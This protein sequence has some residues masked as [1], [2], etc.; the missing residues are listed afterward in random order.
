MKKTKLI[1]TGIVVYPD[2]TNG[3]EV[4]IPL[5]EIQRLEQPDKKTILVYYKSGKMMNYHGEKF[6]K[7]IIK[8]FTNYIESKEAYISKQNYLPPRKCTFRLIN[9]DKTKEEQELFDNEKEKESHIKQE[10]RINKER[11]N[12]PW[13]QGFFH[14]YINDNGGIQPWGWIE[15][16]KGNNYKDISI[17]DIVFKDTQE[18]HKPRHFYLDAK[19]IL[20]D[21]RR[22]K[23]GHFDS[24]KKE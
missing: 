8:D 24:A 7:D 19:G 11:N 17:M 20:A 22:E 18:M 2:S 6:T 12:A 10:K 13:H 21:G 3:F 16:E 23:I 15:D 4:I 5:E 9:Y 14:N 1:F